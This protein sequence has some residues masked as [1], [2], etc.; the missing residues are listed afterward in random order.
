MDRREFLTLFGLMVAARD[1]FAKPA[2]KIRSMTSAK[3]RTAL[4]IGAGISGLAAAKALQAKGL[5]VTVLEARD[6]I[7]GRVWTSTKWADVPVD[8][9]ASWIHGMTGN[10]MT[11]LAHKINAKIIPTNY[12]SS[13][14]YDTDGRPLAGQKAKK[15]DSIRKQLIAAIQRVQDTDDDLSLL[16]VAES[17]K[18]SDAQ[19]TETKAYLN[20]VLNGTFEHEFAG[21]SY[22]LSA[23]WFDNGEAFPGDDALFANG[24]HV[25]ADH[26]AE[27]LTIE[28]EQAVEGIH[29]DPSSV[30]VTTQD[31]EYVANLALVT[32]P[33]GVL[34]KGV[35]AFEPELSASKQRAIQALG[36]GVLNKCYLKFPHAFWPTDVDWL[37]YISE[38]HGEWTEWVSFMRTVNQPVLLGFNAAKRG[39]EIEA[40][41]DQAIVASAMATLQI[42]YG[43]NIPAPID[44]QI[45]RWAADRYSYGSYS[46]DPVGSSP[47]SRAALAKP[48]GKTLFFAGEATN[49]A[50][51]STVHGAYLSGLRAA[52][53]MLRTL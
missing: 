7:G 34:K 28:L 30:R 23:Q 16:Q 29:R 8:M 42:L 1:S 19:T 49:T 33:L 17:L 39:K 18:L 47:A 5:E 41:S 13:I 45:T 26:L 36:M 4:V 20:F 2:N 27:G 9:G 14:T 52:N 22:D 24:Y 51:S 11:A 40:L 3:N 25:I 35:I 31:K 10:P 21:S 43:S 38:H 12:E 46:F 15:L 32:V 6:R 48:E 44:Y 37:E 50:Y 53:E